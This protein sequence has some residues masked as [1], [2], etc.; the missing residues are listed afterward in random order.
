MSDV[1]LSSTAPAAESPEPLLTHP[2]SSTSPASAPSPHE[3]WK[4]LALAAL[5]STFGFLTGLGLWNQIH[6]HSVEFALLVIPLALAAYVLFDPLLDLIHGKQEKQRAHDK[7]DGS[8]EK[9]GLVAFAVAALA[10]ILVSGFDHSL[11]IALDVEKL[12]DYLNGEQLPEGLDIPVKVL[13]TDL[14]NTAHALEHLGGFAVAVIAFLCVGLASLVI[15]YFWMRGARRQPPRAAHWGGTAGLLVGLAGVTAMVA[16]LSHRQL[17]GAGTWWVLALVLVL[18]FFVPGFLGG[19]AVHRRRANGSATHNILAYLLVSSVVSAVILLLL[20]GAVFREHA[21]LVWLPI[22]ALAFQNLGW[23]AGPFF[24]RDACDHHLAAAGATVKQPEVSREYTNLI[25]MPVPEGALHGGALAATQTP[26]PS[27]SQLLLKPKGDRLWATAALVLALV[28]SAFAYKLGTLRPDSD[29]DAN[30]DN[31]FKQDSGLQTQ[32]LKVV[33]AGRVVTLSGSVADEAEHAKALREASAVRGVKQIIDQIQVAGAGISPASGSA[34]AASGWE[35]AP[36][37]GD[38]SPAAPAINANVSISKGSSSPAKAPGSTHAK[39]ADTQ[40]HHGIF[41]VFKKNAQAKT[42]AP[43]SQKQSAAAPA[44]GA[45]QPA[46]A[47]E[48]KKKGFFHFL[49]KDKK[50]KNNT[51]KTTTPQ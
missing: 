42:Q 16:Y 29:I 35:L 2:S 5:G 40:K 7:S 31:Q 4:L 39:A 24:R 37:P 26:A 23:A 47:D 20:A 22:A 9:R 38:T 27:P 49:K 28:T 3:P 50:D 19:L 41:N 14:G 46:A 34:P 18:W 45:N 13:A 11:D 44:Q 17:L 12:A 51:N 36:T 25:A 10:T 33:S 15:T 43:N 1:A 32:D 6:F 30:I 8:A 21:D 48:G